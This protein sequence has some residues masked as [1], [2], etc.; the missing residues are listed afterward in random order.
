MIT[1]DGRNLRQVFRGMPPK[2]HNVDQNKSDVLAY[3]S[4]QLN[5]DMLTAIR[6]FNS[7]RNPNSKVL[8]F[9]SIERVWMGC[10]WL[11]DNKEAKEEYLIREVR[12]WDRK[13]ADLKAEVSGLEKENNDLKKRLKKQEERFDSFYAKVAKWLEALVD[14]AGIDPENHVPE[15]D[16]QAENT[17]PRAMM[18][19]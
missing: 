8:V 2:S 5:S 19:E 14:H 1:K 4:Q 6:A 9:D 7:M 13:V 12:S 15:G 10:D 3:I 17:D 11:P 16:K 18:G